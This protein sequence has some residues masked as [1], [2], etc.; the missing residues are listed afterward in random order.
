MLHSLAME[1][2]DKFSMSPLNV[3]V[4][5]VLAARLLMQLNL[6]NCTVRCLSGSLADCLHGLTSLSLHE[7]TVYEDNNFTVTQLTNL[8]QLDLAEAT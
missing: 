3:E 1:G 7:S 6:V 4:P 2:S 5:Q 8:V